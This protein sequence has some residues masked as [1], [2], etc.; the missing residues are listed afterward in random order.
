[1]FDTYLYGQAQKKITHKYLLANV[2][3]MRM[4]QLMEGADPL[5]DSEN[6]LPINIALKEIAEGL[7]EPHREEITSGEDL[8]GPE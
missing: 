1:M 7:I 8:F 6:M 2:V 5:V 3:T 4:S